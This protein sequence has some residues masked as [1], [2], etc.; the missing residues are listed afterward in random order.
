MEKKKISKINE[1]NILGV[2]IQV[3]LTVLVLVF[4]LLALI[5]NSKFFPYVYLFMG[6]DLLIMAYNNKRVF[7]KDKK[8]SMLYLEFGI[9]I[10]IYAILKLIGVI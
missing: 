4:V 1:F 6:L 5:V 3:I 9:V 10:I 7:N 2:T 8:M